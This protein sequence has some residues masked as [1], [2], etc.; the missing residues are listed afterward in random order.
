MKA[1]LLIL[2]L[3]PLCCGCRSQ[4]QAQTAKAAI[5]SS[6][7]ILVDLASTKDVETLCSAARPIWDLVDLATD[8]DVSGPS[9]A[10]I[11]SPIVVTD[12]AK[13]VRLTAYQAATLRSLTHPKETP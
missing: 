4:A 13:S 11:L 2:S 8:S 9:T 12:G 6:C 7:L 1:T 5:D 3:L 10:E